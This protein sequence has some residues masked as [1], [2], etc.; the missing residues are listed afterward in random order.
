M[1]KLSFEMLPSSWEYCF[2]E[3]CA[4]HETCIR[5]H[6][7]KVIPGETIS[8]RSVTPQAAALT[9]CPYYR[10]MCL[11]NMAWGF[12]RLFLDV[13]QN[14][15]ADTSALEAEIDRLVYDL[16]GLTE[17]EIRIVEEATASKAK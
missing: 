8:V 16:Y 1:K 3:H 11:V 2:N 5:W 14:P 13:K 17:E 15:L 6:S 10:E 9:D 7:T 4:L 12:N